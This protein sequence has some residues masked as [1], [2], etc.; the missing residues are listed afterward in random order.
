MRIITISREFGSGGRELG[1]RL[2]DIWLQMLHKRLQDIIPM[3]DVVLSAELIDLQR[4][5]R[6]LIGHRVRH[7]HRWGVAY[8]IYHPL[9][10]GRVPL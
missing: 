5:A 1:K 8:A 7:S 3:E 9:A 10:L 6:Q 4:L 2:A